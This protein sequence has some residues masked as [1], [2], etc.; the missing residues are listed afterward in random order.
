MKLSFFVGT[1]VAF[2][3]LLF[4]FGH[5]AMDM[6]HET[7]ALANVHEVRNALEIYS[8]E[9][10]TYPEELS[11]LVPAYLTVPE[12]GTLNNMRYSQVAGGATYS[13]KV[14]K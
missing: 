10:G 9:H 4:G 7:V 8:V 6:A 14:A 12:N 13:L 1:Y 3:A 2:A 5:E 11:D